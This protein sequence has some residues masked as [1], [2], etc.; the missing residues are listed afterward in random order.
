VDDEVVHGANVRS[1]NV[2]AQSRP[3]ERHLIPH[4]L[5]MP[6]LCHATHNIECGL[7]ALLEYWKQF[8]PKS[9]DVARILTRP[10]FKEHFL[11]TCADL[12]EALMFVDV[13]TPCPSRHDSSGVRPSKHAALAKQFSH[14]CA[15]ILD[16]RWGF[17]SFAMK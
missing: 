3:E 13:S 9:R 6:G 4:A 12:S 14:A 1:F 16:W 5:V 7:D 15:S 8:L 11:E 2:T 17:L 10:D